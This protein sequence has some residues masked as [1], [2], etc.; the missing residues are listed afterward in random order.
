[1]KVLSV[2]GVISRNTLI[3]TSACRMKGVGECFVFKKRINSPMRDILCPRKGI[4]ITI[5]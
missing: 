1:M 4:I 2:Y 3:I 5:L